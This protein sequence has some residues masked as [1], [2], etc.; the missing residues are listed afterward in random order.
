MDG[1]DIVFFYT[2]LYV[3]IMAFSAQFIQYKPE[4]FGAMPF[5]LITLVN[6]ELLQIITKRLVC[7]LSDQRCPDNRSVIFNDIYSGITIPI[8]ISSCQNAYHRCNKA[9]L[10]V[11]YA[12]P[13][14]SDQ[15]SSVTSVRLI[16]IFFLLKRGFV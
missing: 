7:K 5:T 4:G 1:R 3:I 10:I 13:A 11:F 12:K 14:T 6:H 16:I 8:D 2:D 9:F 15:F